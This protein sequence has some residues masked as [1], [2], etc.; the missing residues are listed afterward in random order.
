MKAKQDKQAE[1]RIRDAHIDGPRAWRNWNLPSI[2]DKD[3]TSYARAAAPKQDGLADKAASPSIT[4]RVPY[5][6]VLPLMRRRTARPMQAKPRPIVK[7][8]G[9]AFVALIWTPKLSP[10]P[11]T[12][13]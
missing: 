4:R 7:G 5:A 3:W 6:L 12:I 2:C 8:S 13:C 11:H 1:P 9:V 10:A